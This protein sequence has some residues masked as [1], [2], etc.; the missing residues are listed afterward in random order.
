MRRA[1]GSAWCGTA[2]VVPLLLAGCQAPEP[3][4]QEQ[5]TELVTR[6]ATT[7]H[8]GACSADY[9]AD[10]LEAMLG[11]SDVARCEASVK[12]GEPASSVEVSQ[13]EVDGDRASARVAF[14][15]GD[16]AGTA[17]TV[18]LVRDED[19]WRV[20]GQRDLEVVDRAAYDVAFRAA[21]GEAAGEVLPAANV[22][23]VQDRF[24][25]RTDDEIERMNAEGT[26]RSF[27]AEAVVHCVASGSD[28]F[29][30][31][32][33]TQHALSGSGKISGQQAACLAGATLPGLD[34]LT[35]EDVMTT[36]EGRQQWHD[37]MLAAAELG[38]C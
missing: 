25:E 6:L 23:C 29:A 21:V 12:R 5:V 13:V 26:V 10:G 34:D 11:T 31:V 7:A 17:I 27:V 32:F 22:P 36:P 37:A 30:L 1:R 15:G 9:T 19:R 2:V 8:P 18:D 24:A 28:T 35:V 16:S 4:P 33:I 3:S 20:D 14:D 38:V